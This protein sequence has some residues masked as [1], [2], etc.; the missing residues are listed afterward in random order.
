MQKAA[1]NIYEI[2]IGVILFGLGIFYLTFQSN[3]A[4]RFIKLAGQEVLAE[5][6]LYRQYSETD[7]NLVSSQELCAVIMG[8]RDFPIVI[9]GI[10]IGP[11]G[12]DYELYFSYVKE[13]FYKKSYVYDETHNIKQVIYEYASF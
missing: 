12:L 2:I 5:S 3:V 6:D 11:D 13:G 7:L 8:N 10:I 9:D 1:A 4:D